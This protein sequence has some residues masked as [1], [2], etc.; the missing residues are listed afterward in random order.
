MKLFFYLKVVIA[1]LAVAFASLMASGLLLDS[2][3]LCVS[4][5]VV[6]GALGALVVF[7]AVEKSI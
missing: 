6:F 1:A 3:P 4:A 2:K 5:L 7:Y